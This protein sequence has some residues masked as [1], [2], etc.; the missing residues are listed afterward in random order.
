MTAKRKILVIEDD[1]DQRLGMRLRLAASGYDVAE[2][3]D[4]VDALGA[5]RRENPDLILLDL[6][7]PGEDG[8]TVIANLRAIDITRSTPIV[9]ISGRDPRTDGARARDA[10]AD[11][12]LQKPWDDDDLL[13]TI[14]EALGVEPLGPQE[15]LK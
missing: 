7:L 9:V 15:A 10:G 6:G 8:Y 12:F 2:A 11:A 1:H 14:R 3:V 13:R 5:A 4:G